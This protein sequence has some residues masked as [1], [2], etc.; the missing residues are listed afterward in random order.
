LIFVL[1]LV[2]A[3]VGSTGAFAAPL[4]K[5][6]FG[7]GA[8]QP[9]Q[10]H[11]PFFVA[12]ELGYWEEEG[13]DVHFEWT[14][15][16]SQAI[17]LIAAGQVDL[18]AANHDT[19]IFAVQR[20]AELKAVFQEHTKCEFVF[21]VPQDSP[22]TTIEDLKG[23][24]IGVSSLSSGF[25]SFA[26]AAF[27]EA[28]MDYENDLN[29][30]EVGSGA[31]A[32]KAIS[33]GQVDALGLWEVAFANLENTLGYDYFRYIVPPIYDR[34]ACNATMTSDAFI[35]NNPDALAGFLRGVAKGTLFMQTNPEAAIAIFFKNVPQAKPQGKTDAEIMAEALHTALSEN[36]QRSNKNRPQQNP[37]GLWGF[38]VESEFLAA[39]DVHFLMGALTEKLPAERY[40]TNQFIQATNDFDSAAIIKQAQEY[41]FQ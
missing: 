13:I 25:V 36:E 34:L 27:F 21:A 40:M 31:T 28:G 35:N 19:L 18:S 8:A 2:I 3:C 20:G 23:K 11:S 41:T 12:K 14:Q 37:D 33:T 30:I 38:L 32:A 7:F 9:S 15:G 39:Q 24:T 17:Q 5:V 22:I 10:T 4:T 26:K 16:S 6:T 29:L 1:S